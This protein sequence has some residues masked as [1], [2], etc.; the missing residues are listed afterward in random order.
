MTQ[1]KELLSNARRGDRAAVDE[2]TTL[3]YKEL[4]RIAES[5]LRSERP[6]HTLQATAL[7]HEVYLRLLEQKNVDWGDK[8][9]FLSIAAR[10]MRRILVDYARKRRAT[11]RGWNGQVTLNDDLH[12][13]A[14]PIEDIIAVDEALERLRGLD[15]RQAEIVEMKFFAGLSI[16]EMSS[17]L[18]TSSATVKR[19]WRTARAWLRT[20][21]G[22]G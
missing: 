9:H 22:R 1:T 10:M 6:S 11:K 2:L 3:V 20:A 15:E 14:F 13:R 19:E 7:I 8:A 5:F 21:L 17:V 18:D 4:R 16:E 12:G